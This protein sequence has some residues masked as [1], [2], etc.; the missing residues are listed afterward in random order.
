MCDAIMILLDQG[1]SQ[2]TRRSQD[3]DTKMCTLYA[4]LETR[5]YEAAGS[6]SYFEKHY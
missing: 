2:S 3:Y 5:I 6:M 1:G 4:H